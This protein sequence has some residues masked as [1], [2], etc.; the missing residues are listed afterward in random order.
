M[1]ILL[2]SIGSRGDIQP[3][4]IVG[5]YLS[6]Q[7]HEVRVS[8]AAMYA[9]LAQNY[10]VD[11]YPFEGDYAAIVD[12]EEM[13]KAVGSNP[14]R[15]KKNLNEKVYPIL[16]NSLQTFYEQ[17]QWAD[18]VLYHPKTLID[19]FGQSIEAR[20]I[21]MYVVPAF[22]P[23]HAFVNPIISFLPL[24]KCL[25]RWSYKFVIAMMNTVKTPIQNFRAK[26]KLPD[27]PLFLETPTVYGISPSLL[28]EPKDYPANHHFT[29]FWLPSNDGAKL[30]KEVM[31]FVSD[32]KKVLLITFG[33]MPYKSNIPIQDYLE[34]L[35]KKFPTLKILV[36]R[37]WGLQDATI[38]HN[39][40]I[41]A[42]DKAPFVTL[43]PKVDYIIHHGGAGTTATALQAGIP[44]F[45][46]PVLHPFGDQYFWGK[47]LV[48]K[49][50]G[51]API[52]LK[53]LTVKKLLKAVA[54]LQKPILTQNA[55]A[56]VTQIQQ[57]DGL[58][59]VLEIVEEK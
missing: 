21:K 20:L 27:S 14:F 39:Q 17:A 29:G 37:A 28:A 19:S 15:M 13:K 53:K 24:P 41:L 44:Q 35:Q 26:N 58:K 50:L 32:D 34:A 30:P 51:V 1:K 4:L 6:R 8:S 22:T 9:S 2:C 33:S 23:T 56:F 25:Y 57:E 12:D 3:F 43:F 5:N 38:V 18:I 47:Q 31:D 54:Q 48:K 49:Q 36:V 55:R 42:I 45:I 40:Q 16:Q 10:A 46:C 59:R 11:Y 52:P 7:G